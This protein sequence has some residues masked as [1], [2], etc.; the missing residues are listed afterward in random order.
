[1]TTLKGKHSISAASTVAT[2][3]GSGGSHVG[4]EISGGQALWLP[5]RVELKGWGVWGRIHETGLTVEKAKELV[6]H[7]KSLTPANHH[8]GFDWELTDKDQ[9]N[10]DLKMMVCLWLK[11]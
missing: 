9:V 3:W 2:S 8:D 7:V 5:S 4:V 6:G 10:F 1:M 11:K